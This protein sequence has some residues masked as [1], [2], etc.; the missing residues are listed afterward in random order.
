MLNVD[1]VITLLSTILTGGVLMLFIESQK[2]SANVVERFQNIMKPFYHKLSCYMR[3]LSFFNR[4]IR[5]NTDEDDDRIHGLKKQLDNFARLGFQADLATGCYNDKQLENI[6]N[7]INNIWIYMTNA[8]IRNHVTMNTSVLSIVAEHIQESIAEV[9]PK[10][11]DSHLDLDFFIQFSGDFYKDT[12]MPIQGV[13][14]DYERWLQQERQFK[15]LSLVSLFVT[16]ASMLT[17]IL[18]PCL[19]DWVI[20]GLMLASSLL[21]TWEVIALIKLDNLAN[22]VCRR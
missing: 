1:H 5:I 15:I 10:Y 3:V 14:L 20:M 17:I 2:L 18:V 19:C 8:Y 21:L 7:W 11:T 22:A 16:L 12:Y 13:T 9:N 4:A 6:C